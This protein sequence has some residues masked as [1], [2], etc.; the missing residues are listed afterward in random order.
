MIRAIRVSTA[1]VVT[2]ALWWSS[3]TLS[4]QTRTPHAPVDDRLGTPTGHEV[5][6]SAGSY[7][8]AEPDAPGISIHGPKV[9][10]EYAGTR[11]LNER[12][13]WFVQADMRSNLG[14]VTYDGACAPW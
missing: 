5:N 9:G 4:A 1:A 7:T 10:V 14:S 11:S 12:R 13:R 8:Y 2:A 3:A 6:L